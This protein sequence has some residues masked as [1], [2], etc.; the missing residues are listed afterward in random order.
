MNLLQVTDFEPFLETEFRIVLDPEQ[1]GLTLKLLQ[2]KDLSDRLPA[3]PGFRDP[4]LLLFLGPTHFA[5]GQSM[6]RIESIDGTAFEVF[7]VPVG[8]Q[9]EDGLLYEAIFN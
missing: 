1:P 5:L 4:F 2:V 8:V 9:N 6:Y 7:L 3:P